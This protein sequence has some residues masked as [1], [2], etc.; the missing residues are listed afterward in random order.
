ML[1]PTTEEYMQGRGHTFSNVDLT[2]RNHFVTWGHL[3]VSRRPSGQ[4]ILDPAQQIVAHPEDPFQAATDDAKILARTWTYFSDINL[5]S[6]RH[7]LINLPSQ[8]SDALFSPY[9]T[10]HSKLWF[11]HKS[12]A[13]S[14]YTKILVRTLTYFSNIDL[15]S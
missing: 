12:P 5:T 4:L 3:Q 8:Q 2:P 7:H 9:S 15:T 13:E 1:N 10:L 11:I 14:G 6:R